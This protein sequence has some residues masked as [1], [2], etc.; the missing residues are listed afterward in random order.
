MKVI[1]RTVK[2]GPEKIEYLL[3]VISRKFALREKIQI[4]A[5]D[6]KALAFTSNL[7]WT[8]PN[9]A[10]LP[11][12][13]SLISP[14]NDLIYLC[15]PSETSD[16]FPFVFNLCPTPYTPGA[17]VKTLYEFEDRSHPSKAAL[18]KEKFNLY[19]SLGY[20]LSEGFPDS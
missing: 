10:F 17:K 15:L 8:T 14:K 6:T 12:S 16:E 4:V 1:F 3:D 20:F 19:K 2:N 9:E 11:H 18:F 5:P 13:V 7:L